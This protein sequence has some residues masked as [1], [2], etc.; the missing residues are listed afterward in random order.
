MQYILVKNKEQVFLGPFDWKQRFIQSEIDQLIED[1]ELT[2]QYQVPPVEQGY[3]NIGDG[4]EIIPITDAS[5]P[6]INTVFEDPIGPFYTYKNNEATVSYSKQ[7]RPLD[8]IKKDLKGLA[9]SQRY[10]KEIAGTTVDI[11]GTTV[12]IDTTREGRATFIQTYT[13]MVDNTIIGWK[14]TE[15]WLNLSKEEL[16]IIVNASINYVQS[17]FDWEYNTCNE[18]DA[19]TSIDE[20]KSI[21]SDKLTPPTV[22]IGLPNA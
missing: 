6:P 15:S 3:I 17:Q 13:T 5:I 21:L 9:G 18:I 11:Q 22:N 4:F 20:L 19:S 10:I 1:D 16:G 14:F 2:V 7:D 8:F 12:T